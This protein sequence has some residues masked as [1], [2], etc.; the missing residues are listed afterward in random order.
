ME[1]CI[2]NLM[3]GY[4]Y[5]VMPFGLGNSPTILENIINK[6]VHD[7]IDHRVVAYIVIYSTS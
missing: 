4:I 1:D 3:R 2:L 5:L 6:I 7:L